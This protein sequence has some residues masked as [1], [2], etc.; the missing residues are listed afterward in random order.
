M[1]WERNPRNRTPDEHQKTSDS[2]AKQ[3]PV[4]ETLLIK[5]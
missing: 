1:K 3:Y 2:T 5:V 4:H